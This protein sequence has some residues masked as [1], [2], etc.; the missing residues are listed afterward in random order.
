MLTCVEQQ[1]MPAIRMLAAAAVKIRI[2]QKILKYNNAVV[3][4][5]S[6]K[7]WKLD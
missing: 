2:T 4:G 6:K 3:F 7:P 5:A 1:C